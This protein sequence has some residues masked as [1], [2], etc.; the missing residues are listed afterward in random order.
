MGSLLL[1]FTCI[2][3][4]KPEDKC[5]GIHGTVTD[6]E[7]KPINHAPVVVT[8]QTTN[9]NFSVLTRNDGSYEFR[10]LPAGTYSLTLQLPGFQTTT[11]YGMKLDDNTKFFQKIEMLPGKMTS[12]TLVPADA[13]SRSSCAHNKPRVA[14]LT[15]ENTSPARIPEALAPP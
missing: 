15:P 1:I 8:A 3:F 9:T 14:Q 7:G 6:S 4:A 10:K 11:V 5:R 2:P 13:P 12:A